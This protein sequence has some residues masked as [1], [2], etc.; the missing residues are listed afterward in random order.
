MREY[1]MEFIEL[2]KK[3]YSVRSY[4]KRKVESVKMQMILEAGRVAPTAANR[5]PQRIL[6][7]ESEEG[8]EKLQKAARTFG[9]PSALI[10]CSDT[11]GVW[12]RPQDGMMTNDIDASIIT[13]HMMLEATDLGLGTL[14]MTW[15]DPVVLIK[16]F[17]IPEN[18]KPV[19]LLLVGYAADVHPGI[20]RHDTKRKQ[21]NETVFYE[22]F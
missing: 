19:N 7:I 13:D 5:Q 21:L 15:F 8:I 1:I 11:K 10:I 12:V 3:R 20:D 4:E 22:R 16:E 6:L 18:Y 17:N 2:A 14:W 9:A